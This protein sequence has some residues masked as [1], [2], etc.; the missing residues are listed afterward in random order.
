MTINL[1]SGDG[2][3]SFKGRIDP[4]AF[5]GF[6]APDLA[7]VVVTLPILVCRGSLPLRINK[8]RSPLQGRFVS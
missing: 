8:N 7:D 1:R 5:V 6:V 4:A 3:N 2:D